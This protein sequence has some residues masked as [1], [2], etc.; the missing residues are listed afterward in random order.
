MTQRRQPAAGAFEHRNPVVAQP[1]RRAAVDRRGTDASTASG[2]SV[3]SATSSTA[4]A[5][6]V[7]PSNSVTRSTAS[8]VTATAGIVDHRAQA[9]AEQVAGVGTGAPDV[10]RI[11][12]GQPVV[13]QGADGAQ[14]VVGQVGELDAQV[15]G[16]V[17]DQR[18]FGARVVHG[19]D[20]AAAAPPS[21]GEQFEGV[22]ELGEV[23]DMHRAGRRRRTPAMPRAHPPAHPSARPPWPARAA[24]RRR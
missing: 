18:P 11:G 12:G 3:R 19:R 10:Q 8:A 2:A 14:R 22:G 21:G 20:A 13:E 5:Y 9:G 23:A 15:V 17:G 24:S 16:E 7:S 6:A 1:F 4:S